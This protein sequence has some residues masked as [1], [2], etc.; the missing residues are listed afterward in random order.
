MNHDL[1]TL[2]CLLSFM[3]HLLVKCSCVL[4]ECTTSPFSLLTSIPLPGNLSIK[5][6]FV[7]PQFVYPSLVEHLSCFQFLDAMNM[8]AKNSG[9]QIFVWT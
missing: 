9:V 7:Y 4:T 6:I 3:Q 1:L 2:S 8:V 5:Q